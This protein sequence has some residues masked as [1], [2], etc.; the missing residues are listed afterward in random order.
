MTSPWG[1]QAYA[2]R[3]AWG[4]REA[5]ELAP[6]ASAAVVVDVLSFS[7]CIDVAVARGIAVRPFRWR[8][9]RAGAEARS[10][11]AVLAVSR[12][13]AGP[14]DVTLS[15]ASLART[16]ATR[17]LLPSPNG[18][19]I[20]AELDR[21]CGLVVAGSLR[22][23]SAVAAFLGRIDGPVVVVAAGERWEDDDS[24]RPA[25]E[26]LWGAGAVIDALL[27]LRPAL[28]ASPEALAA[29]AAYRAFEDDPDLLAT[30]AS[31]RE[32]VERGYPRDV[33][34]A[35]ELDVSAVVPL[36]RD[37]WFVAG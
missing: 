33:A 12:Q 17:V 21:V 1:Q 29:R 13:A 19:T 35:A 15:P 7:T 22:N 24:L 2:A 32:L 26:D 18:S 9:E 8:D 25:V 3:V 11:D 23:R 4:L 5:R 16:S 37:G 31:G 20:S 27:T 6:G 28:P 36:L 10:V 34:Y 14:D 30:C